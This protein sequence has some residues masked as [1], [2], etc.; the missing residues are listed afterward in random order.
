MSL[1]NLFS[2]VVLAAA[3][4]A[5]GAGVLCA[6]AILLGIFQSGVQTPNQARPKLIGMHQTVNGTGAITGASRLIFSIGQVPH[7]S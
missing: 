3:A 2:C 1:C 4:R 6:F 7:R 5:G